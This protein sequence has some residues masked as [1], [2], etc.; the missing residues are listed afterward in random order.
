[1][2]LPDSMKVLWPWMPLGLCQAYPW[3]VFKVNRAKQGKSY[4]LYHSLTLIIIF[5]HLFIYFLKSLPV[6]PILSP[7]HFS[8][9]R[10]KLGSKR[11]ECPSLHNRFAAPL[12]GTLASTR[13]QPGGMCT[14]TCGWRVK[15]EEI[16]GD[17]PM[18]KIDSKDSVNDKQWGTRA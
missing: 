18:R 9:F 3:P 10:R 14:G 2:C 11:Q 7:H 16:K 15:C 12:P 13:R 4:T 5:Y 17:G 8:F 6:F 1:M